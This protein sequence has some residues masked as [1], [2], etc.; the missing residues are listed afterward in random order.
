MKTSAIVT[1]LFILACIA[2]ATAQDK[3]LTEDQ[4]AFDHAGRLFENKNYK[5]AAEEFR[6]FIKQY[7]HSPLLARAHYNLGYT[8]YA[9]KDYEA[10]EKVFLEIL[11]QPY[12]E[13]DANSLMEPYTLYKHHSCRLLATM[14]IEQKKFDEAEGYIRM[15]DKEY[16]YQHFCG[17][18]WS[19]Y[20][21]YYS[22]MLAKVYEGTNRSP[23]AIE[24]LVP[25]IFPDYLS[26][27]EEVNEELIRILQ[28]HFTKEEI[29]TELTKAMQSLK[30]K[31]NRKK[32]KATLTL[33]GVKVTLDPY[34]AEDGDKSTSEIESYKK[35]VAESVL[36]KKF[37]QE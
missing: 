19:A 22:V 32:T 36:F 3:P 29:R 27:D 1:F 18:E 31:S 8:Y 13:T 14:C 28:N 34:F 15:F 30:V 12:N 2:S 24:V 6:Q 37:L 5:G 4:L 35:M 11:D 9:S 7:P 20:H 21:K 33:F 16:P 23:K 17:N 26:S 10:A 25:Y